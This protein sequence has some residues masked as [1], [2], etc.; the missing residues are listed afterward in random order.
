MENLSD[1]EFGSDKKDEEAP[2]LVAQRYLNIFRQIHIFNKSKRDMFDDELLALPTVVS[3]FF[4][5]MPGGRLLVEHIEEVK[6]ERGISFVKTNKDEFSN[7]AN[8]V[9]PKP[10]AAAGGVPA[11]VGGSLVIDESFA[12]SLAKSMALAFQQNPM[13]ATVS[14]DA[15]VASSP[16]LDKAFSIIAEE[17]KSSRLSLLDVLKE[18]RSVT[19]TVIASQVSISRILEGILSSRSRDDSS[20][21]DLNNRII[22]SQASITKLLESIYTNNSI[23]Q[24]NN[25][26]NIDIEQRLQEFRNE[27]RGEINSAF[28]RMQNLML[29]YTKQISNMQPK[30]VYIERPVAVSNN[31]AQPTNNVVQPTNNVVQP[32]NN[33]NQPTSKIVSEVVK[34]EEENFIDNDVVTET[35]NKDF[36]KTPSIEES[37]INE[38]DTPPL[39]NNKKKKK[40]KKKNK[41]NILVS[42]AT[43]MGVNTPNNAQSFMDEDDDKL[44]TDLTS[45][46][47]ISSINSIENNPE[48][49]NII[50][51]ESF[52]SSNDFDD[53]KTEEARFE[54]IDDIVLDQQSTSTL[55]K[56]LFDDTF[57]EVD[58]VE[59]RDIKIAD[60]TNEY[61]IL[62]NEDATHD[63]DLD[64]FDENIL[65][66]TINNFDN[67]N[68]FGLDTENNLSSTDFDDDFDDGL[69]FTLPDTPVTQ[70]EETADEIV[71][72]DEIEDDGLSFVLPDNM[73]ENNSIK[74]EDSKNISLDSFADN[75]DVEEEFSYAPPSMKDDILSFDTFANGGFDEYIVEDEDNNAIKEDDEEVSFDE[76]NSLDTL[77]D[78][79]IFDTEASDEHFFDEDNSLEAQQEDDDNYSLEDFANNNDLPNDLDSFEQHSDESEDIEETNDD[80]SSLDSLVSNSDA[81]SDLDSFEQY[82]NASEDTEETN[83]NF[84]SLDSLISNSDTS[85][86]LDN[87]TQ[88][89]NN[90]YDTEENN[91][92][93]ISLDSL[94]YENNAN[95]DLTSINEQTSSDDNNRE[96]DLDDFATTNED[97]SYKSRYSAE[98]DK[99]RKALTADNID[100][101]SL[102]TPI[103]LDDYGNNDKISFDNSDDEWEYEYVEE[104]DTTSTQTNDD[105]QEWEY[106]YVE[107][108]NEETSNATSSDE[109]EWEYEYVDENGNPIENAG[110]EDED[111]EWEYVEE[112]ETETNTNNNNQ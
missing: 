15:P 92:E 23:P 80:F 72:N 55:D 79:N 46:D 110:S 4:K 89:S 75:L 107:E 35:T 103:S 62:D 49:E 76:D 27:I 48:F 69:N 30:T 82:S 85:S 11:V 24:N 57:N 88:V 59:I 36:F 73:Q 102:D 10:N 44:D 68:D 78:N 26:V 64:S 50:E 42:E 101:S 25:V 60:N 22:A 2:I 39:N 83:D 71:V 66:K 21:A 38:V 5:R 105:D 51:K 58:D 74:A 29:E 63:I 98:M 106:E 90:L 86:D 65:S 37:S 84:S 1:V 33:T 53:I 12:E 70:I 97:N 94:V 43:A 111:W 95:E 52:N 61:D 34:A 109:G 47:D 17:I 81:L 56:D 87:L 40:K 100:I 8:D 54:E 14:G 104:E 3:D 18:T 19:D 6:T 16:N 99:I 13:Q 108:D 96:I 67:D 91:N 93:E 9:T 32:T 7:G 112:D 31:I 28:D 45:D 20:S 41:N 77:I